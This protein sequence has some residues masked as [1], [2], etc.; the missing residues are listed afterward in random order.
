[1]NAWKNTLARL[2]AAALPLA[3]AMGLSLIHI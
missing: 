1:M 3:L 2:L